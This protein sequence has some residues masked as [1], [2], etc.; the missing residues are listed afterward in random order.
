[1]YKKCGKTYNA[2]N[3]WNWERNQLN[4]FDEKSVVEHSNSLSNLAK[5]SQR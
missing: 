2:S 5:N 4:I 1:M 3:E